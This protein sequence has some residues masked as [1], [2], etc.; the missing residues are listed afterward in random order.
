MLTL[1]LG[2]LQRA[3]RVLAATASLTLLGS[4][5]QAQQRIAVTVAERV[6][7]P[8]VIAT[9]RVGAP[10]QLPHIAVL[11]DSLSPRS[12]R[13]ALRSLDVALRRSAQRGAQLVFVSVT[14]TPRDP[15]TQIASDAE[16]DAILLAVQRAPARET[17]GRGAATTAV[18]TWPIARISDSTSSP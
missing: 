5:A 16:I 18:V 7:G 15:D 2:T 4:S 11:R 3:A 8:N 10:G 6:A 17:P 12:L 1:T 13:L 14:S 9:V